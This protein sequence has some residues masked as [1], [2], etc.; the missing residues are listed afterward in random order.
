MHMHAFLTTALLLAIGFVL[1]VIDPDDFDLLVLLIIPAAAAVIIDPV[2]LVQLGLL[3]HMFVPV[4]SPVGPLQRVHVV[5]VVNLLLLLLLGRRTIVGCCRLQVVRVV[6]SLMVAS[7]VR[8][9]GGAVVLLLGNC[10]L[11]PCDNWGG[12]EKEVE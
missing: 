12:E 3:S 6:A 9:I 4:G 10:Q 7:P 11:R 1:L 2:P 5:V 8:I